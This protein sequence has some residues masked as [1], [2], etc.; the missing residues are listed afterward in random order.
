[1]NNIDNI[2][3]RILARG[4]ISEVAEALTTLMYNGGF[5]QIVVW[6]YVLSQQRLA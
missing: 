1:M 4:R 6:R 2:Q 3:R 5:I